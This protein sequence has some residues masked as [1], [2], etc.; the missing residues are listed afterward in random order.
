MTFLFTFVAEMPV[1]HSVLSVA[2]TNHISRSIVCVVVTLHRI[3]THWSILLP[4]SSVPFI[5]FFRSF[6]SSSSFN[7]FSLPL[8][9][10]IYVLFDCLFFIPL[11]FIYCFTL[12]CFIYLF[13][14]YYFRR[15]YIFTLYYFRHLRVVNKS[16]YKILHAPSVS[17]H[18]LAQILL[19]EFAWNLILKTL[20]IKIYEEN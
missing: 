10:L 8:C 16:A 9:C 13:T 7:L 11:F 19:D 18:V 14:L 1:C 4:F 17:P 6:L 15:L 20:R 12:F 3:H 2:H 5:V